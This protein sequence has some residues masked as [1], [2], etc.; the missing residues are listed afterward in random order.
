M[1]TRLELEL[2]KGPLAHGFAGI[3]AEPWVCR[4]QTLIGKLLRQVHRRGDLGS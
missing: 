3:S 4:I 1:V 2:G